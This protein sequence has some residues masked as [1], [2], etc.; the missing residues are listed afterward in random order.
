[1]LSRWFSKSGDRS[2]ASKS[3]IDPFDLERPLLQLSPLDFLTVRD[4][5]NGIGVFGNTGSGKSSTSAAILAKSYLSANFGGLVLCVKSDEAALWQDYARQTGRL[6]DLIMF[7]PEEPFRF[8]FLEYESRRAGRGGGQTENLVNLFSVVLEIQERKNSS[9]SGDGYW[10]RATLQLI[11]NSIDIL[12]GAEYELSLTNLLRLVI[13]APMSLEQVRDKKWQEQSYCFQALSV[14]EVREKDDILAHDFEVAV[15]YFLSEFP[16]LASRTRSIVISMLTSMCD[17]LSRGLLRQLFCTDLTI[18]PEMALEGKIIVLD[19]PSKSFGHVG[20]VIQGIFKYIF[21]TSCERRDISTNPRPIFIFA[22]ESPAVYTSYDREFQN[23]A[24]SSRACTVYLAQNLPNY[25]AALGGES[26][27]K[28]E[29]EAFL[30]NLATKIFHANICKTTNDYASDLISRSYQYRHNFGSSGNQD[31]SDQ[32]AGVSESLD[33]EVLP[34]EFSRLKTGGPAN[35][36]CVEAI[37]HQAGR[38]WQANGKPYLKVRF[39]Q[40][41]L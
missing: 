18:S 12:R 23:T 36:L 40:E 33:H 8:N 41:P 24:R 28:L 35:N 7:R 10:L 22:D 26:A 2:P 9:S 31:R 13:S 30:G 34:G 29:T 15:R 14:G 5:C 6:D 16:A 11:R 25:F 27:G 38:I 1:M 19:L 4:A 37:I 32:S 21:Q 3:L 20:T 17:A 39:Q